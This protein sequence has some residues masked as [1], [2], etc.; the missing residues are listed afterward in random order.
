MKQILI[1]FI[2]LL[3]TNFLIAQSNWQKGFDK[4]FQEGYCYNDIG[5]V[6]PPV[7]PSIPNVGSE[8]NSYKDGYN[9]GF[10]EGQNKK[11][12][13]TSKQSNNSNRERYKTAKP[14][15]V[16]DFIYNPYKNK[17]FV[18]L[19]IKVAE[20]KA[21][22]IGTLYKKGI[23]SYDKN[24]YNNAIFYANEIIKIDASLAKPYALKAMSYFYK[25]EI[26]N[27]YNYMHKAQSLNYSGEDNI[28][29]INEKMNQKFTSLMS[30]N[31]FEDVIYITEKI[32]NPNNAT[33]YF[34]GLAL[35]FQGNYKKSKKYLKKVKNFKPAE[36]YLV[37]IKSKKYYSNPF[38]VKK[39][40]AKENEIN[41]SS[42]ADEIQSLFKAKEFEKVIEKV[43]PIIEK[44]KRGNITD[45]NSIYGIYSLLAYCHYHSSN[46]KETIKYSTL[47]IE[48][49][50]NS[51]IGDIY[52]LRAYSKSQLGDYYGSNLDFDYLID[53][54][55]KIEYKGNS[56]A[57][58][59][60]NKAYNLVLLKKYSEAKPLLEKALSLD[61]NTYYI[62]GTKGELEYHLGNYKESINA[63]T[64]AIEIQKNGNS[65]IK[66]D[67]NS[68]LFR[69]LA[70]IK[71]GNKEKGCQ[72]L[73]KAGEL[74]ESKAYKEIKKHCN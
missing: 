3:F 49:S 41:K 63:M 37:S 12:N 68:F 27:S 43:K 28:K 42:Y 61:K 66:G 18:N 39:T 48:N 19:S 11:N 70:N 17:D 30:V 71:L 26:I 40:Q 1:T 34:K 32:W 16:D 54:Y 58:L 72:D 22:K 15:F 10:A 21:K 13:D 36:Q 69:G 25:S 44:I 55:E 51:E 9:Q 35:Y 8:Y 14:K 6:S 60:N 62:W 64:I 24:D 67:S 59:I 29:F 74:G 38:L 53:N 50:I 20:L 23:E 31:R 2:L 56:K 73:S 57:T 5:C 7:P 46:L 4:G 65:S 33:N 52:F 47:A 45:K